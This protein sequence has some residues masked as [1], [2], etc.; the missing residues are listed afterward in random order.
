MRVIANTTILSNFAAVGRLDVLRD[1]LGEVYISTDVYAEIQDGLAE[2]SDFYADIE[3]HIHPVTP[4]GW[5]RLTSPHGDDELRLFSRLPA[6]LH[7]GEASCLTIAAQRGWA[8]LT[9]D[10]RARKAARELNVVISGTLGL[11]VQA[12]QAGLLSLD[13]ANVLLGQMIQVGYRS[14]Y[15]DLIEL[16]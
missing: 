3:S 10:A 5:L 9:D 16:L 8:L 11:L 6:A 1:L 14:P 4:G 7:R 13:E 12:T 15:S 2:G